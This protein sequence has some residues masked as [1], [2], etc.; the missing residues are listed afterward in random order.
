MKVEESAH[1][2]PGGHLREIGV[3]LTIIEERTDELI[4]VLVKIPLV[5]G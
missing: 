2:G 5:T 1:E 3:L 4:C